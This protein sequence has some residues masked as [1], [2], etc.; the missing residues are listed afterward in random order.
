MC[1]YDS[2]I[3][4]AKISIVERSFLIPEINHTNL[5]RG[6]FK[7]TCSHLIEWLSEPIIFDAFGADHDKR[8]TWKSGLV[9][10]FGQKGVD[11]LRKIGKNKLRANSIFPVVLSLYLLTNSELGEVLREEISAADAVIG[12]LDYT[13]ATVRER[14]ISVL[15]TKILTIIKK[16]SEQSKC[17]SPLRERA[18]CQT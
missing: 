6:K 7:A 8:L 14:Q 10:R 9:S 11:Y 16:L 12:G 4:K 2:Y 18:S 13:N 5:Y 17:N 1:S 3:E 15:E